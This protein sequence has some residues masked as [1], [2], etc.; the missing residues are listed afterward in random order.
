MELEEALVARLLADETVVALVGD[1][2]SM[3]ER[4][5]GDPLPAITLQ[6][7]SSRRDQHMKGFQAVQRHRVQLDVWAAT[8]EAKKAIFEAAIPALVPAV[9][10]GGRRF[11]RAMVENEGDRP[12]GGKLP[13]IPKIFRRSADLITHDSPA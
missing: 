13:G 10:F 11:R 2:V 12:S 7:I 9:V 6:L 4:Q 3:E 5:E 1:R 8:Y